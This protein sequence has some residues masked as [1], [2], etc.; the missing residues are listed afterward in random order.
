MA[1]EHKLIN[2]EK[3]KTKLK[4]NRHFNLGVTLILLSGLAFAI[5]LTIPFL[6]LENQAKVIGTTAA[7][8]AMEVLF[9]AGV[10]FVGKELFKKYKSFLN[11]KNWFKSKSGEQTDSMRK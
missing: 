4:K 1:E 10:F 3:G 11:P 9:Y 7:F 8:I 6:N 2:P 5:M